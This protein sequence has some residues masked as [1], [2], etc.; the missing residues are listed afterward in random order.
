MNQ[1][2][3]GR[4]I[5]ERRKIKKLTQMEL[6]EKLGVSNRTISKWENGN[7]L[8]DYSII[9]D[10]CEV[11]DISINELLSGEELT[12]ENYQKKLE[13]NIVSTIDYNN[14]K[15]NKRIRK[16]I[17]LIILLI[18]I[19]LLYKIFIAYFYYKDYT[20]HEDNRFP[21]N[22]NIETVQIHNND[23][24][25]Q[26]VLDNNLNMY[27][28]KEFELITDRAKSSLVRDNCEPYI[29]GLVDNN[30]FDAMILICSSSVPYDIGNIEHIG[31]KNTIFPWMNV[32]S[33]LKKYNIHDSVDLI[34]FY[35]N[36]Y[37]FKQNLFTSSDDIK[38]NYIVRNYVN[39][40]IPSY[41]TFYY[42]EKDLRGYTIEYE[43][44]EKSYFQQTVLSYKG[45]IIGESNYSI[46]FLNN[47]EEYFNHENTFEIISSISKR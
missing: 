42:L 12:K 43:K 31:I 38:I 25:N 5:S 10:L 14:K 30:N 17:I 28:P 4:F 21:F 2:K 27:I 11:L 41:D 22:Q 23:M 35:E 34:K 3:I 20:T 26:K 47:K 39:T 40:T 36:N 18:V 24:A 45:G 15:R 8:P 46:S 9:H 44:G 16:C 32:Y 13:E 37:D 33:L 29:K 19:Y 1:Q 6:A 7:S